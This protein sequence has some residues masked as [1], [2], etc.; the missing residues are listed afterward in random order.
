MEEES[1]V[2]VREGESD[3]MRDGEEDESLVTMREEEGESELSESE[4]I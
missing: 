1:E 3:I 4:V 2:T